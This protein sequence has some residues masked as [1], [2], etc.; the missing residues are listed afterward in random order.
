MS[1]WARNRSPLWVIHG[2]AGSKLTTVIVRC[3]PNNDQVAGVP[4]TQRGASIGLLRRSKEP[5]Q[6]HCGADEHSQKCLSSKCV[7]VLG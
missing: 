7:A 6:S 4:Q 5:E 1:R 3:G 2:L